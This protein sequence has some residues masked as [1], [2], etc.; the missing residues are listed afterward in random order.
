MYILLVQLGQLT[1]LAFIFD[2]IKCIIILPIIIIIYLSLLLF[3]Y[4]YYYLSIIIIIC[5]SLLLFYLSLLL[6][7][8]HY[9]YFTY[10]YYYLSIIIIICLSLLL[11]AY[12]YYY[13]PIII[14]I[15]LFS[16]NR[17]NYTSLCSCTHHVIKS[18]GSRDYKSYLQPN[19]GLLFP[20]LIK[21]TYIKTI[22]IMSALC[23]G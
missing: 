20:I 4:H 7:V 9:Y 23:R 17:I 18:H 6:F 16:K 14:I 19:E 5:L 3:I 2:V 10:H 15:C 12:H 8:Y 11:F 1:F 13:L 21:G 22:S